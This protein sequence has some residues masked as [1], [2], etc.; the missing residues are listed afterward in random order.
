MD[1][2]K[3]SLT[4]VQKSNTD[5]HRYRTIQNRAKKFE[6]QNRQQEKLNDFIPH[7]A[8][9]ETKRLYK[10]AK[11]YHLNFLLTGNLKIQ[12]I[13]KEVNQWPPFK[14]H[15]KKATKLEWITNKRELT[16]LQSKLLT[17]LEQKSLHA[18]KS[19]TVYRLNLELEQAVNQKWYIIFNTLTLDPR[20]TKTVWEYGSPAFTKYIK[21]FE[22]ITIKENHKYFAVTELGS[23]TNREHIHVIHFIKYIPEQAK[24]CPNRSMLKPTRR[25]IS[26]F[27]TFWKYGFSTPIAVRTNALDVWAKLGYRWAVKFDK[28]HNIYQPIES[29]S[30]SRL[31][32]YMT[33]YIVKSLH[34][35]KDHKWKIRQSHQLGMTII[36]E[37]LKQL[38][39][40]QLNQFQELQTQKIL[41]IHQKIIPQSLLQVSYHK[42][43][44]EQLKKDKNKTMKLMTQT[45]QNSIMKQLNDLTQP[46]PL[47]NLRSITNSE[48]KNTRT[49]DTSEIIKI[50][51]IIDTLTIR[52][53]GYLDTETNYAAIKGVSK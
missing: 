20:H 19:T 2:S 52:Y 5:I 11:Y 42:K 48:I 17:N 40:K 29:G 6:A 38:S 7:R 26:Y 47:Y 21:K 4:L 8:I 53:T 33:K 39:P 28:E 30:V 43:M 1:I 14:L 45:A 35:K 44:N 9:K 10:M 23:E 3:L 51:N 50:Q 37:T 32:N 31:A 15:Y 25:I 12:S 22:N 34:T 27:R 18:R 16:I 36:N 24:L 46:R 13:K 41:A 49:M